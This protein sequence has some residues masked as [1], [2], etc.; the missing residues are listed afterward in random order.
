[1]P[2]NFPPGLPSPDNTPPFWP[3]FNWKLPPNLFTTSLTEDST[4]CPDYRIIPLQH[5][6]ARAVRQT[7]VVIRESLE[8]YDPCVERL[9][10]ARTHLSSCLLGHTLNAE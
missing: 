7:W 3:G 2:K 9:P 10:L 5:P 6:W 1:M 8:T 4:P